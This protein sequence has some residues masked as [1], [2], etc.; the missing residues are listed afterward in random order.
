MKSRDKP[1]NCTECGKYHT[2][3]NAWYGSYNC[4]P[5]VK[6]DLSTSE[7]CSMRKEKTKHD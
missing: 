5:T 6:T 2:C 3:T 1:R 4:K 7:N